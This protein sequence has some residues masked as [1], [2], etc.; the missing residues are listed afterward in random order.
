M[1]RR[2]SFSPTVEQVY[3]DDDTPPVAECWGDDGDFLGAAGRAVTSDLPNTDPRVAGFATSQARQITAVWPT[4][5][6]MATWAPAW[7]AQA[8]Q[9]LDAI[10]SSF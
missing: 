7:A 6:D 1:L 3:V 8:L 5:L 9:D 10:V 2:L 4:N